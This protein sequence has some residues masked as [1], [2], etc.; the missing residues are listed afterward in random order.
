MLKLFNTRLFLQTAASETE[1]HIKRQIDRLIYLLEKK[2]EEFL[3]HVNEEYLKTTAEISNCYEQCKESR[4]KANS[5]CQ[6]VLN[7]LE[8]QEF[9]S[10]IKAS[11]P[12][13]LR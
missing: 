2:K 7:F 12:V 1:A 10:Y 6:F 5:F 9:A 8:E 13:M 3:K 11:Q 4:A